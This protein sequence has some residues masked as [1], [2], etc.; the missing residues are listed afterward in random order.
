M[1]NTAKALKQFFSDFGMPAY[2]QNTVPK[3]VD[4]PYL[5]FPLIEPEWNQKTTFYVQ[6]YFRT[7]SFSLVLEKADAIAG[8]IGNGVILNMDDGYLVLY[9]ETPLIQTMTE[10]DNNVRSFYINLSLNAYHLAG[11]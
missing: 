8:A 1:R 4:Y 5:T 10:T 9:P 2:A 11:N 3:D 7:T 6:G